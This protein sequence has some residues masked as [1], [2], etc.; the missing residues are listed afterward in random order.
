MLPVT[1]CWEAPQVAGHLLTHALA[2]ISVCDP[3]W[4]HRYTVYC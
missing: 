1:G 4:V 2:A 3:L